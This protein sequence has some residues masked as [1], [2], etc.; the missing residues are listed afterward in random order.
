MHHHTRRPAPAARLSLELLEARW[1][2]AVLTVRETDLVSDQPGVAAQTD[3]NLV[4]GWGVSLPPSGGNF[5][6][7]DNGTGKASVYGGDTGGS[8]LTV[9]PLVVAIP[10][11]AP[12]GQVF[13]GTTDFVVTSGAA[14]G[15]ALFIFASETG[16][17]T[18]WNPDVPPPAPSTSAQP[19]VTVPGA[20]YKGLAI[21]S[22]AAGNFLFA[23][24]FRNGKI[25][26]FDK[27][28]APVI[29]PGKFTDPELPAGY[30]PF[31]I[32][33]LGGQLY[34]AYA[35]RAATGDEEEV[36][37]GL[38]VV[39]VFDTDGNFVR[40]VAAGGRLDAPWGLALAPAGFGPFGG[41]LL[42]G[43]AG[44]GRINVFDPATGADE[45]FLVDP[46]GNPVT[47]DGLWGLAFGN[48]T[49]AGDANAL[50]FAA[51]SGD[52]THGLFGKLTVAAPAPGRDGDGP[53]HD[54]VAVS[55]P[56]NG[57]AQ[58]FALGT[59]GKLTARGSPLAVFSG[60]AGPVRAA[61][62]DVDGDGTPDTVLVTGP[63]G[64]VQLA[65]VSGAD[66]KTLLLNPT[67]PFGDPSFTGGA[68]VD[69]GDV[70]LDGRAE[71]VVSPDQGGGPRVVVLDVTGGALQVRANFFGIDDPTFRGG[72]R[73]AIG[74]VTGDGTLDLAVAAG[75]LGGPRVAVFEGKSVLAGAAPTRVLNDFFAFPGPDA[76]TLRNGVF[77]T[78][79]D[80]DGD[81]KADLAFGG[82]P[83]G[84]PRVLVVSGDLLRQGQIDQAVNTPIANFFAFDGSQRGGVRL[85]AKEGD[86]D[87]RRELVAGSGEGQAPAVIVYPGATLQGGTPPGV[88]L[89]PFGDPTEANGIFV[90]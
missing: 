72:A 61:T 45:G 48:G 60:F 59:T 44:D 62:G 13:N 77:L 89:T 11:G 84:G 38:G 5:W 42:V 23:A 68:F 19:A 9:S 64:P 55:G 28:Y 85:A 82:G 8:P 14:S 17:I 51:G 30:A 4:N 16:Q 57:A 22:T 49:T 7:S 65:V 66:D 67:D 81:G 6:V 79:G 36:G 37:P 70:D 18:G 24:D 41:D 74:D 69:V 86:G 40:R 88:S 33:A 58:Q 63:G 25:D 52:E 35:R 83:G 12:T 90:G 27:T 1:V 39:N 76:V 56:A 10:G 29:L 47:I 32:Q 15:P 54:L 53:G 34:V 43:N 2:P 50:Y 71:L 46:S 26:V 20:V 31:N 21:G 3:P 73:T 78:A 80:F 75:F 87:P